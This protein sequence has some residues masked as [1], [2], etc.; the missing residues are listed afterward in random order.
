VVS[1][2]RN[3][4]CWVVVILFLLTATTGWGQQPK[5]KNRPPIS[6]L[7]AELGWTVTLEPPAADASL[8]PRHV[9]VPLQSNVVVAIDRET[10]KRIWSEEIE[11]VWPVAAG[12]DKVFIAASDELHALDA[13]TGARLWRASFDD[14]AVLA[15]MQVRGDR[16]LVLTAPDEL[17]ALRISDGFQLWRHEF[18]GRASGAAMASDDERVYV[19][20]EEHRVIAVDVKDGR[21]RWDVTLPDAGVLSAPASG[22]DRVFLASTDNRLHALDADNGKWLWGKPVGG[23]VVGSVVDED[24]VYVASLGNIIWGLKRSN[25]NQEWKYVVDRRPMTAPLAAG[26]VALYVGISKDVVALNGRTG[27]PLGVLATAGDM[28]GAPLVAPVLT[29]FKLG[30]WVLLTSGEL[31]GLRPDSM[32]FKEKPTTPFETFFGT[33]PLPGRPVYREPPAGLPH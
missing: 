8:D 5:L 10:G 19:V 13:A 9:Y 27:L 31:I 17:R 24:M 30:V 23:D 3:P 15:P 7:P 14:R 6:V 25:G 29:P 28:K 2:G 32:T 26:G 1:V 11:T 18:G 4:T 16:L 33:P 12:A 21:T 20:R 22:K